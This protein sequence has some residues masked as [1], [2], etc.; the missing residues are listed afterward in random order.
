MAQEYT[1]HV[2]DFTRF[3]LANATMY[4]DEWI[5][6]KTAKPNWSLS[7]LLMQITAQI[8]LKSLIITTL[9]TNCKHLGLQQY[10]Q[11]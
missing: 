9:A 3:L 7:R 11:L 4:T 5:R 2:D 10:L 8:Y 6:T 1:T